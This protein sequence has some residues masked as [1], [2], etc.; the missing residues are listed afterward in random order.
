[1]SALAVSLNGKQ[2]ELAEG[3]T[4]ADALELLGAH[5]RRGFAVAVDA[6]VVP[7]AEWERHRLA[8]GAHVEVVTALRGG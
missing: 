5:T 4:V 3:A 1:V 7:R 6:V 2:V 8:E